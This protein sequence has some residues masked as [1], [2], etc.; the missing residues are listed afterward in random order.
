MTKEVICEHCNRT[1][2]RKEGL[3]AHLGLH[4][5]NGNY[6]VACPVLDPSLKKKM[7]SDYSQL[8]KEYNGSED[9]TKIVAG[10][11]KKLDWKCSTCEHEWKAAGSTRSRGIGCPA[12]ANQAIHVDGRN[13]MAQTHPELSKEYQGDSTKVMA[14][15][16]KK[17]DWKCST[18]EHEWKTTGSHRTY[19]SSCPACS[20]Q[21]IHIDG[22]NSMAKTHPKLAIEYQGDATTIFAGTDKKLDWKCSICEHEWK[23]S[24]D[25]TSKPAYVYQIRFH[26]RNHGVFYKCGITNR[27]YIDRTKIIIS[28][29]KK[30]YDDAISINVI[31]YVHFEEGSTALDFERKLKTS[32]FDLGSEFFSKKFDGVTETFAPSVIPYWNTLK[33]EMSNV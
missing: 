9:P 6:K 2:S 23:A 31:D 10:T 28:S 15:T 30:H 20:N 24:G 26:T 11:N 5:N 27:D 19:G 12:C 7:I 22:R 25:N 1:F 16:H 18:C 29:Y 32:G 3:K 17:L 14:G 8:L 13:S 33:F 21:A 4:K